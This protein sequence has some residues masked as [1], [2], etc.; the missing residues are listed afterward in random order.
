MISSYQ[1]LCI[2]LLSRLSAEIFYPSVGGY[3]WSTIAAAVLTEGVRFLLALPFLLYSIRGTSF[4]GSTARKSRIAGWVFAAAAAFLISLAAVRGALYAAEFA[5]RT[6]LV[7]MSGAVSA[8]LIA[9]F[10]VYSA[11]K[12]AEAIARSGVIIL[13]GAAILT[14]TIAIAAI[15]HMREL[16]LPQAEMDGS[17]FEQVYERI[18]RG[19]EYMIFAALLPYVKRTEKGLSPCGALLCFCGISLVSVILINVFGMAVLGEFY[20]VADFPFTAAAQ[21][22]DIALFKRLDGFA[23]AMWSA[24]AALRCGMLLFSAYAV[25]YAVVSERKGARNEKN[26]HRGNTG[27]LSASQRMR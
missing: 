19:G 1:L 11:S 3:G 7:G 27:R 24:A 13:A 18:Y 6:V 10:A 12:G 15:P 25:I 21:L 22:S 16:Q 2:L 9:T 4:Y 5:Q 20:G 14:V 23:G 26:T 8:V 17:F